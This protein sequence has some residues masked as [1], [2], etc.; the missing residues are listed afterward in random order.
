MRP[1]HSRE[2]EFHQI[3]KNRLHIMLDIVTTFK[4][5][6]YGVTTFD[7]DAPWIRNFVAIFDHFAFGESKHS[8]PI[9]STRDTSNLTRPYHS[10]DYI[11]MSTIMSDKYKGK[12]ITNFGCIFI[13]NSAAGKVLAMKT[14]KELNSPWKARFPDQDYVT[15]ALMESGGEHTQEPIPIL[16]PLLQKAALIKTS[17]PC[18]QN[19]RVSTCGW[20][21][22]GA[23]G[24]F[25]FQ[26]TPLSH[27]ISRQ[28][29]ALSATSA[30]PALRSS[31]D[32]NPLKEQKGR[33]LYLPQ[34]VAPRNCGSICSEGTLMTQHCGIAYCLRPDLGNSPCNT[35]VEFILKTDKYL[36]PTVD[37]R[38]VRN[39]TGSG[40]YTSAATVATRMQDEGRRRKFMSRE[41]LQFV[42]FNRLKH[43]CSVYPSVCESREGIGNDRGP[44]GWDGYGDYGVRVF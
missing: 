25:V 9:Q 32:T 18:L 22:S 35:I 39:I 24:T 2:S 15:K 5:Y 31:T 8:E 1:H 7:L 38:D 11:A 30:A 16:A 13:K 26:S 10:Y 42:D 44:T 3:V 19:P 29:T 41:L 33:Y 28:T 27:H 23:Q 34:A 37:P 14:R 43:F 21:V 20:A 6:D 40:N 12:L 36:P 17:T 4:E